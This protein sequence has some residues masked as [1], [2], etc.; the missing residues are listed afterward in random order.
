MHAFDIYL[1]VDNA[2]KI[3]LLILKSVIEYSISKSASPIVI[4]TTTILTLHFLKP[5]A[6][7]SCSAAGFRGGRVRQ[8]EF[9]SK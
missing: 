9:N 3:L 5:V 6:L 4:C 7:I 1:K 2:L 8:N